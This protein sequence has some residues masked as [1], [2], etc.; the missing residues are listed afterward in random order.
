[1]SSGLAPSKST[2][3]ISNLPFSLTNNDIHKLLEHHGKIVKVTVVKDRKSRKSKGV[4][5]V[6]FLKQEEASE[7]AKNINNT[8]IGGRT[9]KSSI[10]VDNGRSAD[11]IRRREYPDKSQC[12]EC[13]QEGHLS[14][15][16][17]QNTLGPRT[18]PPKKIRI[19]KKSK[20]QTSANGPTE[21]YD[22][23]SDDGLKKP[24]KIPAIEQDDTE[25][26]EEEDTE[27]LS[28][29]IRLEQEQ[30]ELEEYRNK[31][32]NGQYDDLNS[33]KINLQNRKRLKVSNYLSDEDVELSD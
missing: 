18:P 26:Y 7:C 2:V 23:D 33:Q 13:G 11:F 12:W 21:Y 25:E 22:S 29:A 10:A 6:L 9:V 27:T 4:A 14:Y 19:R 31:V 3:Y 16:C 28:A 5:F 17:S 24:R 8:E 30:Y 15:Q 32:A 1:M 20:N